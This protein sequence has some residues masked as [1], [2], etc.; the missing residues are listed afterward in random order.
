MLIELMDLHALE[1]AITR[2]RLSPVHQ[3]DRLSGLG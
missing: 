2:I 1:A 3:Y